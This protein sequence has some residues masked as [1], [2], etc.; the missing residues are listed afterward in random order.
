MKNMCFTADYTE[1]HRV[2]PRPGCHQ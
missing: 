1:F 2:E